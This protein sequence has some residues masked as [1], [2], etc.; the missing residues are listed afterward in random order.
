MN[1]SN[2]IQSVQIKGFRSLADFRIEDMPK[3]AVLIGANGSGKS[4][5]VRFFDMLSWMLETRN[6]D[7]FVQRHGGADD[8]LFGGSRLTP[9]M[10][11][12]VTVRTSRGLND[13]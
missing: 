11:A 9:L 6:L 5:F 10:S 7:E 2:R 8:Q 4:N 12:A 1:E 3:A 13:Y